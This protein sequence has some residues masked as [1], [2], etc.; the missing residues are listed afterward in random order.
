MGN[1]GTRMA[2][3]AV[4]GHNKVFLPVR[5]QVKIIHAEMRIDNG[6]QIEQLFLDCVLDS[7]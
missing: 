5:M 4:V 6:M 7:C 2:G 1:H 3:W